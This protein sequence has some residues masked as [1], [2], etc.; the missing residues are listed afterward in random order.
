MSSRTKIHLD[1]ELFTQTKKP[2]EKTKSSV[3]K[4]KDER[5]KHETDGIVND[6]SARKS[7]SK[8]IFDFTLVWLL[9][10]LVIFIAVGKGCLFYSDKVLITFLTTTTATAVGLL[11]IVFKYLFFKR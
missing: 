8:C 3:Q 6:I 10:V 4:L 5:F 9:M 11:V 7:F 1:N 2:D